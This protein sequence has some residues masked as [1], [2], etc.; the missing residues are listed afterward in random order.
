[1]WANIRKN[2]LTN[3]L[4]MNIKHFSIHIDNAQLEKD[5][6]AMNNFL[7]TVNVKKTAC[8]FMDGVQKSWSIL[9]FFEEKNES[10]LKLNSLQTSR[11]KDNSSQLENLETVTNQEGQLKSFEELDDKDTWLTKQENEIFEALKE[12]RMAKSVKEKVPAYCIM[13]NSHLLNIAKRKP[14][15]MA[16]LTNTPGIGLK[17]ADKWGEE[18]LELLEIVQSENHKSII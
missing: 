18:L 2:Y 4:N 9:V 13:H 6:T 10:L 12:W 5:Q 17:K 1:L 16:D 3:Y 11:S 8:E 7:N 15:N 14:Q